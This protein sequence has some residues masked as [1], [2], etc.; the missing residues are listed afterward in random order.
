MAIL[1]DLRD[2]D[3]PRVIA[4]R[5]GLDIHT[6]YNVRAYGLL[7]RS[8][9]LWRE[10]ATVYCD[11]RSGDLVTWE[12]TNPSAVRVGRRRV[13]E[14]ADPHRRALARNANDA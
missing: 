14:A 12:T 9:T 3:A 5:Y 10:D 6:V 8:W 4:T 11:D 13:P 2:G 1:M 7:P